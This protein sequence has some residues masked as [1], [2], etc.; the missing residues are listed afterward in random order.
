M[1]I[2]NNKR[3]LLA[4]A[5]GLVAGSLVVGCCAGGGLMR[6]WL[7]AGSAGPAATGGVRV[8]MKHYQSIKEDGPTNEKS[9]DGVV[10]RR[11]DT[12]G[13]V[14]QKLG[15]EGKEVTPPGGRQQFI[16]SNPDGS[17]I[18]CY[19]VGGEVQQKEQHGLK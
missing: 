10:I 3:A 13:D 5:A 1:T 8:T 16:W 2:L 7:G 15:F 19:F 17:N 9:I 12:Y 6:V 14:V 11:G 18:V 4:V